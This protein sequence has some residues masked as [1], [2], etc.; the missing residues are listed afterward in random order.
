MIRI[1]L[2]PRELQQAAR[3]PIKLFITFIAG[4]AVTLI[5]GFA[6]GYLWFNAV[7]L[8]ERAE[9][10]KQEVEHLKA[11]A[12]EVD[13]LLDDIEDYKERERAILSIKTNRILWSR[14]LD[15]LIQMTPSYVWIIRLQMNE[16]DPS[17][18][19]W[20]KGKEQNGGFL[21][22]KCYSSGNQV[23]RM[24]NFRQKLKNVDEFYL[25][26]LEERIKPETFYSD[27]INISQPEWKFVLLDGFKDPNN[28]KFSVRLDLRPLVE[29][30]EKTEK[31]EA[32][33]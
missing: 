30:I 29:K 33:A 5:A 17:E 9:R 32:K 18:Y 28:I 20:E 16:L 27:F 2:L 12:A 21:R 4:V 1:N 3:T 10:K 31:K 23:A 13:S 24:T 15:E 22:L 19:K 14:K 26:F 8:E 25:K 11:N 7:V 6:Y